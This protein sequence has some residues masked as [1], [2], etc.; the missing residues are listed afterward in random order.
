MK[1]ASNQ[2]L[3]NR[4]LEILELIMNGNKTKDI[5]RA[6]FLSEQTIETHR[7]N[8]IRKTGASNI[9]MVIAIAI[10]NNLISY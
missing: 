5:A 2:L 8:M 6:L 9:I 1:I 3:S 4:E 10:K 7:K